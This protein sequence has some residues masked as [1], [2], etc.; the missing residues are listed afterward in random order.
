M[1]GGGGEGEKVPLKGRFENEIR[2][3]AASGEH[4]G[5]MAGGQAMQVESSG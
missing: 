4:A 5:E 3:G 1:V 2:E